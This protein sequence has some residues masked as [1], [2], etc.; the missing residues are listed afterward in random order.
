MVSILVLH[1]SFIR[2]PSLSACWGVH[3]IAYLCMCWWQID[4][5]VC[6]LKPEIRNKML[7]HQKVV[8]NRHS[9]RGIIF[10]AIWV[11]HFN[12]VHLYESL[13]DVAWGWWLS[14]HYCER[15]D[16]KWREMLYRVT[17]IMIALS[18]PA[19]FLNMIIT[20]CLILAVPQPKMFA[21]Y[22]SSTLNPWYQHSCFPWQNK[23]K[24]H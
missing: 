3:K 5:P 20:L 9:F 8:L 14:I 10:Y 11:V 21:A 7:F 13:W 4:L 2:C 12:L 15:P 23:A 19:S 18:F 6:I 16:N 17:F 1:A 24:S 22:C